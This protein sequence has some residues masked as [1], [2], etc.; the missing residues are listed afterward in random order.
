MEFS[1]IQLKTLLDH[2]LTMADITAIQGSW[3]RHAA[4][5]AG[6]ERMERMAQARRLSDQAADGDTIALK[7]A[8]LL[9]EVGEGLPSAAFSAAALSYALD[10]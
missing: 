4:T 2:G 3:S 6:M 9:N 1:L 7:L 5:V 8:K 10:H